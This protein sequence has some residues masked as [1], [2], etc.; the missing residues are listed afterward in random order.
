MK[1]LITAYLFLL[2]AACNPI[3]TPITTAPAVF[4]GLHENSSKRATWLERA[5]EGDVYSQFELAESFC[6]RGMEGGIDNKE[7]LKWYCKAAKNG[8]GKAQTEMGKFYENRRIMEGLNIKQNYARA[9]MWY[10][11]AAK[12]GF[13][14]ARDF[15]LELKNK[16]SARDMREAEILL[17][18]YKAVT[19]GEYS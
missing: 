16:M 1:Y 2:I 9:Y 10:S 15:Q 17:R 4:L 14:N 11:L 12:R 5:N 13:S 6:C 18:D 3:T 7:S 8:F 19:C